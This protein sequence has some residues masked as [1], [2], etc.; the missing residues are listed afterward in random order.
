MKEN[1]KQNEPPQEH[2]R[3]VGDL[4]F[5]AQAK[6]QGTNTHEKELLIML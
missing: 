3:R 5:T 2:I 4:R 1:P 6:N